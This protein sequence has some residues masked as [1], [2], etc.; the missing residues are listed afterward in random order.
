MTSLGVR[1]CRS[2][3]GVQ[4][5]PA[6]VLD[7]TNTLPSPLKSSV[8]PTDGNLAV[9]CRALPPTITLCPQLREHPQQRRGIASS[10]RARKPRWR[11]RWREHGGGRG[12][13]WK[14]GLRF[15]LG[16]T[17]LHRLALVCV[18]YHAL[19]FWDRFTPSCDWNHLIGCG[20][21]LTSASALGRRRSGDLLSLRRPVFCH[22]WGEDA[23]F[24]ARP[25][26]GLRTRLWQARDSG[27]H[28]DEAGSV[29]FGH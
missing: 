28:R 20:S 27:E 29:C 3:P 22:C 10:P 7:S 1:S 13:G 2:P 25:K 15:Y 6:D 17:Y 19:L 9:P 18:L 23:C 24:V 4:A 8:L 14:V 11:R 16:R 26:S 21:R 5:Y 12:G